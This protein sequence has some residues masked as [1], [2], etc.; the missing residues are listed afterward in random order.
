MNDTGFFSTEKIPV[1]IGFRLLNCLYRKQSGKYSAK[2]DPGLTIPYLGIR[3]GSLS[4]PFLVL[5]IC[6]CL[7]HCVNLFSTPFKDIDIH[8]VLTINVTREY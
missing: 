8:D 4:T 3:Y 6:C 7:I 2:W 1:P 5:Y